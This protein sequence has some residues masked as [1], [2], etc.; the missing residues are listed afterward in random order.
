MEGDRE[1]DM[2]PACLIGRRFK[3]LLESAS[4]RG[5]RTR[6]EDGAHVLLTD[7]SLRFVLTAAG[8]DERFSNQLHTEDVYGGVWV[9]EQSIANLLEW[10]R[11]IAKV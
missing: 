5:L 9:D 4:A 2:L 3:I 10:Y 1:S 8:P 6:F 11:G 7:V